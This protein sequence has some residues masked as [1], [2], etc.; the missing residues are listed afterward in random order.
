MY[1]SDKCFVQDVI[2]I[3]NIIFNELF[4]ILDLILNSSH[5]NG[6]LELLDLDTQHL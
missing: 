5:Q 2:L 1:L 3:Q 4:N 6:M